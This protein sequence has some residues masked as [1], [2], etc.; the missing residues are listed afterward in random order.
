[1]GNF[2]HI[3][4]ALDNLGEGMRLSEVNHERYW[5]PRLPNTLGWLHADIFDFEEALRL[6][7]EGAAIARELKFP[8][9]EANS[10]VNLAADYLVLGEP[11]RAKPHLLAAE[12][13]LQEDAWFRWLYNIRLQEKFAEYWM[14]KGDLQRAASYAATALEMARNTRRRKHIAWA[15]KLL[16][17]VA[18]MEE[19]HEQA[20]QDYEAGLS[21]L[22]D[23]PCPSVEWKIMLS[24]ANS[25]ESLHKSDE[26][27]RCRAL[28]RELMRRLAESISE[29]RLRTT[30]LRSKPARDLR[31]RM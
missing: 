17:D 26:A 15:Q 6:N 22:K 13:V 2:G 29:Y 27:E 7:R 3:S 18:A 20:V 25:N 10:Y 14:A 12:R 5:L 28:A 30:F 11:E 16:G 4:E 31:V 19:R 24:L 8:E 1:M 21:A 23:H 9:G